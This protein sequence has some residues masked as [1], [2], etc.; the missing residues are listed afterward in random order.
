MTP[1]LRSRRECACATVNTHEG[2]AFLVDA[3]TYLASAL[4][5]TSIPSQPS[6]RATERSEGR[7]KRDPWGPVRDLREGVTFVATH[8]RVRPVV[9]AMTTALAGGGIVIVLGKP[10]AT[11]VLLA[12]SAGFPALLTAFGAPGA[13]NGEVFNLLKDRIR[14]RSKLPRSRRVLVF[15]PHPDDDVI[16]EAET[17][18]G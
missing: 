4:I 11:D 9:L 16:S 6:R 13:V 18:V 14:G 2:L 8:P 17:R 5:I 12:G 1:R 3:C 7:R 10:Y 15:S